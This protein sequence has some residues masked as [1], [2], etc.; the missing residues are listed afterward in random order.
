MARRRKILTF[1]IIAFCVGVAAVGVPLSLRSDS[2]EGKFKKVLAELRGE[3][4]GMLNRWLI[5]H[6]L[7]DPPPKRSEAEILKGLLDVPDERLGEFV[8]FSG[9]VWPH[10][11]GRGA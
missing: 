8:K 10:T 11:S 7:K 5:E 9:M 1:S 3:P 6:K 4:D 2:V